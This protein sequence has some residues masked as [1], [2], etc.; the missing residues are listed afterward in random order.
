[1]ALGDRPQPSLL[2]L[3]KQ[4]AEA[5]LEGIVATAG[6]RHAVHGVHDPLIALVDPMV[7][8]AMAE[9][10]SSGAMTCSH[11]VWP[12]EGLLQMCRPTRLLCPLC[13]HRDHLD[14]KGTPEDI[15]CD[16]CQ[17][18]S[19]TGIVRPVGATKGPVAIMGG[20]C[21]DCDPYDD[22]YPR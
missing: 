14:I 7:N 10:K 15:T 13:A 8:K 11:Y 2:D 21:E 16:L 3:M 5:R 4:A 19:R 18:V 22:G 6:L 17:R 1:M 9:W 20:I 12:M